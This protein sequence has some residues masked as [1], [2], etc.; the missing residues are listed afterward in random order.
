MQRKCGPAITLAQELP[1][2]GAV[3]PFVAGCLWLGQLQNVIEMESADREASRKNA[4]GNHAC[5]FFAF[6]IS[7]LEW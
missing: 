3:F 2:P 1:L 6:P 5:C 4:L 7:G